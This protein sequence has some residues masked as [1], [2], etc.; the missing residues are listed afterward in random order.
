MVNILIDT[1][2]ALPEWI[3]ELDSSAIR[4]LIETALVV[5][6]SDSMDSINEI[7]FGYIVNGIR[8]R[9]PDI[10]RSEAVGSAESLV[11]IV[12][13]YFSMINNNNPLDQ[14]LSVKTIAWRGT[15]L[16]LSL[17]CR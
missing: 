8:K 16:V 1:A 3:V 7:S 15:C 11:C 14:S 13:R 10:S 12:A 5:W 17:K 2:P 4:S 9:W 6:Q